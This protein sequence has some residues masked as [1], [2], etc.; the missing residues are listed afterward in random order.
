[1]TKTAVAGMRLRRRYPGWNIAIYDVC[2]KTDRI[3]SVSPVF[4]SSNI[5]RTFPYQIEFLGTDQSKDDLKILVSGC[6][7]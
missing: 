7:W 1:M 4:Q 5:F 2:D 6:R 3:R